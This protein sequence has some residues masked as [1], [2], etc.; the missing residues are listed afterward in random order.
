MCVN[1]TII[2]LLLVWLG[3][4][5]DNKI[6]DKSGKNPFSLSKCEI[7]ISFRLVEGHVLG[8]A[9]LHQRVRRDAWPKIRRT[10]LRDTIFS[11]KAGD[12]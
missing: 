5:N 11:Y 8:F 10:I 4:S 2:T 9:D 3:N 1:T 12:N 7:R 6:C